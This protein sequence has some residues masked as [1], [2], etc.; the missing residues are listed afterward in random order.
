MQDALRLRRRAGRVEDEQRVLGV[1]RLGRA[2]VGGRLDDLVVPDVA[3]LLHLALGALGLHDDDVLEVLQIAHHRVDLLL[4]RRDL[5]LARG[6]V[7][8]DQRLGLGELHALAHRLG[9]KPPKTTLCTAPMRAQASIAT[10]T[11]GIMAR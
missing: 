8:G 4:D 1:H 3:A 7:D 9:E 6:T 2:L 10:T 5:A 11:S